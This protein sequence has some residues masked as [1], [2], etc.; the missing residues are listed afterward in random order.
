MKF[1]EY[2]D[3]QLPQIMLIHGG[4][5]SS[6]MFEKQALQ[7]QKD[8]CVILPVLDGHGEEKSI[9]YSSTQE[10]ANKIIHYIDEMC[11]G[12]L[13]AIGGASL[14]SQIAMEVLSR[15]TDFIN[16]A[17]LE[18]GICTAKPR[19][20]KMVCNK[21]MIKAMSI[22]YNMKWMVRWS[23]RQYGWP[24]ELLNQFIEDAKALS[25]E[26]NV[27][28]YHTYLNYNIPK[29]LSNTK[30]KVLLLYGSKEKGMMKKD[31][32]EAAKTIPESIV[33]ELVGYNHCGF[34]LGNPIGYVEKL[35]S[36]LNS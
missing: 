26:S 8:Y 32:L 6:W 15:R 4:G 28:L 12:H 27:N 16:K 17:I 34:S 29:S 7:L 31:V 21:W 9:T 2:G 33:E 13:F 36:F 11:G 23:C 10:Q 22:S 3:R 1:Y 30:A 35:R 19:L 24:E 14:G 5:N 18:S 20:A 25:D